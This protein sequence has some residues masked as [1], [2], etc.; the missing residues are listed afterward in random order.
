M[1][2]AMGDTVDEGAPIFQHLFIEIAV[3]FIVSRDV[4]CHQ[5]FGA[6]FDIVLFDQVHRTM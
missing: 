1:Q 6:I 5:Y 3:Q 4:E 2:T